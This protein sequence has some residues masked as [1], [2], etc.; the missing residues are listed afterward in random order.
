MLL[1]I[2]ITFAQHIDVKSGKWTE[3][4]SGIGS[5]SDS[6]Y[7]YLVKVGM[8]WILCL[9]SLASFLFFT[10]TYLLYDECL[11]HYILFPDDTDF[12]IMF[13][14]AY[15]GV[16]N[17][18]RIGDWY[19]DVDMSTGLRGNVRQVFQSLMAFYVSDIVQMSSY[20]SVLLLILVP[21]A[22]PNLSRACRFSLASFHQ[23]QK[24]SVASFSFEVSMLHHVVVLCSFLLRSTLSISQI[25][26]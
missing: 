20:Y 25:F 21:T 23:Q 2:C 10:L 18:S 9:F 26:S 3:T 5:N 7:E 12:W 11:Q 17:N 15:V 8:V 14:A 1:T 13:I 19:V 4:L 16:F 24:H 6:F 22:L